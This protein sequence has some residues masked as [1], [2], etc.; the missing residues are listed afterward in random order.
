MGPVYVW[1][2]VPQR[3]TSVM[4]TVMLGDSGLMTLLSRFCLWGGPAPAMAGSF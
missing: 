1:T 2:S 4:A 3:L